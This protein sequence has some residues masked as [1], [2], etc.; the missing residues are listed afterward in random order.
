MTATP[1]VSQRKDSFKIG[2][3]GLGTVG[4]GVL[5]NLATVACRHSCV[6]LVWL[7]EKLHSS[8]R[9]FLRMRSRPVAVTP[10]LV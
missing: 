10:S 2:I 9:G 3:A 4:A 5:A 6:R 7:S 1:P 8:L